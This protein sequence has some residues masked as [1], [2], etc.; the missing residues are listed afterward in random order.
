L[1][2][3]KTSAL[4]GSGASLFPL[5]SR[6][7]TKYAE[8]INPDYTKLDKILEQPVLRRDQFYFGGMIRSM[9]VAR[10]AKATGKTIAPH[11]SGGGLGWLYMLH[12]VSSCPNAD[13]YHEF[14][15]CQRGQHVCK[16]DQAF[17][18]CAC[19]NFLRPSGQEGYFYTF[20]IIFN[21]LP[22]KGP[23]RLLVIIRYVF[24][25]RIIILNSTVVA[26]KNYQYI[27]S[28]ALLI[29]NF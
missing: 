23:I 25:R 16:G 1:K 7:S 2:F 15:M 18:F 28:Q 29:Q 6:G 27:L 14:K 4:I 22:A 3:I 13:K 5:A 12:Y 8:Q 24:D 21:F 20:F 19:L 10:M 26:G 11:I 17:T 9:K